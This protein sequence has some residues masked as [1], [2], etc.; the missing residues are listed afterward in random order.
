MNEEQFEKIAQEAE[1]KISKAAGPERPNYIQG[2]EIAVSF[3]EASLEAAREEQ[4]A[5]EQNA[6]AVN[7]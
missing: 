2:L 3:L 5:E 7:D 1:A 6:E 4:E